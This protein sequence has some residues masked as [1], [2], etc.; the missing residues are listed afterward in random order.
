M[1]SD[2]ANAAKQISCLPSGS[3][4]TIL[5]TCLSSL[6]TC[7]SIISLR[8]TKLLLCT[9]CINIFQARTSSIL[10]PMEENF[11]DNQ[12]IQW[13][14]I[15]WN[16]APLT[17]SL[18]QPPR[19]KILIFKHYL[20]FIYKTLQDPLPNNRKHSVFRSKKNGSI[21]VNLFTWALFAY[22]VAFAQY[23]NILNFFSCYCLFLCEV[24]PNNLNL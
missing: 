17:H 5:Q 6:Y 13:R 15:R 16:R 12:A 3:W 22:C 10:L 4:S 24:G 9:Y 23:G 7:Y 1:W 14:I 8:L 21:L 18:V 11:C 2:L 19:H 20:N